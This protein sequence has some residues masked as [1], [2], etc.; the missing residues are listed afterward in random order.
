MSTDIDNN[1][2]DTLDKIDFGDLGNQS[3]FGGGTFLEKIG[4]ILSG[5]FA[6]SHSNIFGAVLSLVGGVIGDIL[7]MI[8]L[9]IAISILS[10][11]MQTLRHENS[12]SGVR[13]VIHFVTY[14]AIVVLILYTVA[15]VVM[16]T[17]QTLNNIKTQMD[18]IFPILLA[19]MASTGAS[20]STSIYQPAIVLLSNGIMQIFAFVIMPLFIII[21]VFSIIGNL[22][23][24]S[25]YDKFVDF[26]S[27]IY[28]W[29]LGITF[30]VFLAFLSIQGITAGTHDSISIRATKFTM[31]S[32]VPFMG[33]Y[34]SQ[35]FDLIMA[36]S[37]LI[38]NAIGM[39]GL[40]L[41]FGIVM[42]PLMKIIVLSLG[43]K[44]C[45]AITQPLGDAR[46]SNFLTT[47]TKSF[48][49]LIAIILGSAFMYFLTIGLIIVTGNVL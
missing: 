11:F 47:V 41:L 24:N 12:G 23:P 16:T 28:K 44:L 17:G 25:K 1:V 32:Y 36:S 14:S 33:G 34:L 29:T 20:A 30:T 18:I 5:E 15:D 7:P 13:D 8:V 6:D 46:I 39:A 9:I 3:V 45:A 26:F 35:G 4:E 10:G 31:S 22:S 21:L 2:Q 37:I 40:Y 38:K 49:M 42:S 19:L 43:L 48:N 27:S